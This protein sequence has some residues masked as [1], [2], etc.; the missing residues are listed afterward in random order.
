MIKIVRLSAYLGLALIAL[1]CTSTKNMAEPQQV[2]LPLSD[3]NEL[4]EGS[5]V[6]GLPRTVFTFTVEFE[7]TIEKPGPYARYANDLL[8][9]DNVITAES[10]S[11]TINGIAVRRDRSIRVLC[12]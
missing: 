7:R 8:G 10:E 4:R 6:Y 5:I 2:I 1:S 11:W 3:K 9:L 12:Y